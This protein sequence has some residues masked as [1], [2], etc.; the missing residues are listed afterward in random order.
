MEAL[1]VAKE[2][3]YSNNFGKSA[4]CLSGG[5]SMGL[6]HIGVL[7]ALAERKRIPNIISGA[8][9][10]AIVGAAYCVRT[11]EEFRR[12]FNEEYMYNLYQALWPSWTERLISLIRRGHMFD[13]SKWRSAIGDFT[14]GDITF[15]EAFK[16][17]GK[18]LNVSTTARN[19][20]VNFNYITSPNVI[21]NSA[22]VCSAAMP[23]FFGAPKIFE[24]DAGTGEIKES[25]LE[26]F[27][28]GSLAGDIPRDELKGLFGV[29]FVI[30]SQVNPHL[31]PFIF[32]RK[33][34]PGN[35]VHTSNKVR[36]GFVLSTLEGYLKR[37]MLGILRMMSDN[38]LDF[39]LSKTMSIAKLFLQNIHGDV[40]ISTMSNFPLKLL[41]VLDKMKNR[42]Q[43]QW[44]VNEGK[45]MTWPKMRY[46]ESRMIIDNALNDMEKIIEKSNSVLGI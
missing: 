37:Q 1:T 6:Q 11:D 26:Q 46:I 12:D 44:W 7:L 20:N 29:R 41:W 4:L 21:I 36:G 19:M 30:T 17:T 38:E 3:L 34:E 45:R 33:G 42:E 8:S 23:Y 9:A 22:C 18:V 32:F 10:G 13:Q 43:Y 28:D 24:K 2:V 35:P 31:T 39:M 40:T 14:M 25:H 5:G 15:M 27:A 16:R